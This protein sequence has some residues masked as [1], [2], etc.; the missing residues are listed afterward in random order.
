[1]VRELSSVLYSL[2][3][4]LKSQDPSRDFL[5]FVAGILMY[6][7]RKWACGYSQEAI[8][9]GGVCKPHSIAILL[10]LLSSYDCSKVVLPACH[11]ACR[12]S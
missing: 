4:S 8:A 12:S 11:V 2:I 6:A 9:T 3:P 10:S 5:L 7:L 1:M